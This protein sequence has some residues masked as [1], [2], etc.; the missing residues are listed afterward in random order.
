MV[1][2]TLKITNINFFI[3]V[4]HIRTRNTVVKYDVIGNYFFFTEKVSN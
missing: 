3:N 2:K 4:L 1:D